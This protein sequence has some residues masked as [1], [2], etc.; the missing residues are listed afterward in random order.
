MRTDTVTAD[1]NG[2][3]GFSAGGRTGD[4]TTY[5]IEMVA[6]DVADPTLQATTQFTLS[7]FGPFFRPW[8]TR[9]AA[10]GRPGKVS[11]IEAS[12][13][14]HEIG[15]DLYAHYALRGEHVGTVRVDRLKGPCGQLKR[16]FRQFPFKPVRRG[17]YSVYFDT[18]PF[19]GDSTFEAPGYRRVVVR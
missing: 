8:N 11:Q 7:W 12:G 2:N 10:P 18:M 3:L 15:K 1:V 5:R 16:R 19:A 6:Q 17:T 9:G 13:Y 14:L 4:A